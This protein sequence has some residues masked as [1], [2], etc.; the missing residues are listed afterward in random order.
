MSSR[1]G[2]DQSTSVRILC[3]DLSRRQALRRT[4]FGVWC[5]AASAGEDFTPRFE[6][7]QLI[8]TYAWASKRIYW[9]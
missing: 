4:V 1:G 5:Q 7:Q 6:S 9:R 2:E 8:S 3:L